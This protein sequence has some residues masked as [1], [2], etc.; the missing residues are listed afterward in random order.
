V[1]GGYC[2]VVWSKVMQP[3]E[4]GELGV[5]DLTTYGYVF[6]MRWEWLA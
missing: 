5:L 3:V 1:S 4:L 2:L 6:C